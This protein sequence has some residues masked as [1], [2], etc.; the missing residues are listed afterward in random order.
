M[1]DQID[2]AGTRL[3]VCPHG[4]SLLSEI[5][6]VSKPTG[7]S[8]RKS[9]IRLILNF[10]CDTE[11]WHDSRGIQICYSVMFV[12]LTGVDDINRINDVTLWVYTEEKIFEKA[13]KSNLKYG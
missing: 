13:S 8:K 10:Q 9:K 11:R 7:L 1:Y 3:R 6:L 2:A 12:I 5:D 4:I